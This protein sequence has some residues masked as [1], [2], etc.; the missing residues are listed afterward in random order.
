MVS[1]ELKR[2][3]QRQVQEFTLFPNDANQEEQEDANCTDEE[4]VE[5]DQ[6]KPSKRSRKSLLD[7][8]GVVYGKRSVE[9]E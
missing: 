4:Q 8:S 7:D 2:D 1:V 6:L 9:N 5:T 3:T